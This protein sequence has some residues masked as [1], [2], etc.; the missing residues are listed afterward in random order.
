MT[1]ARCG[2]AGGGVCEFDMVLPALGAVALYTGPTDPAKAPKKAP[3][4]QYQY[5]CRYHQAQGMGG[6]LNVTY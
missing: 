4:G 5:V 6:T 2:L 3:I 1:D